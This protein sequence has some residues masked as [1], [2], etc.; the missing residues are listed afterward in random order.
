LFILVFQLVLMGTERY[1]WEGAA[2]GLRRLVDW[3]PLFAFGLACFLEKV[4]KPALIAAILAATW[5]VLLTNTYRH[6]PASTL[7]EFQSPGLIL[8]WM[9]SYL[10]H[11][12]EKIVLMLTPSISLGIFIP[13]IL[14]FSIAGLLLLKLLSDLWQKEKALKASL[15]LTSVVV[16]NFLAG[17]LLVARAFWNKDA[18]K[19]QYASAMSELSQYQKSSYASL[20]VQSLLHEGEYLGITRDWETAKASFREA[21]SVSSDRAFTLNQ[22]HKIIQKYMESS[23]AD[24][25]LVEL[26]LIK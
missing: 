22:I 2:F 13:G 24:A 1:F 5:T 18:V 20:E 3:T 21:L 8:S 11:L 9:Q 26:Q 7:Y 15:I 25:Y 14:L 23:K 6:L 4:R 10:A 19:T 16:L 17:Y 12:P